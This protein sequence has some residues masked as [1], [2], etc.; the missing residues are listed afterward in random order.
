MKILITGVSGFIGFSLADK[1]LKLGYNVV[2]LDNNN[3]Y[4]SPKF[5]KKRLKEIAKYKN[6]KFLKIDISNKKQLMKI[7]KYKF[8]YIFHFAAQP[9]VRYSLVNPSLYYSSNIIG[10]QNLFE[11][12]NFKSI[13]KVFYASSSSVYGEQKKFP[14]NENSK[15]NAKNPYG[16]SKIINENLAEI[17]SFTHSV[18]FIG[19]R[20][21]TVYG[22]WGRPDMFILKLLDYLNKKKIFKL[23]NS[24]NHYRDFTYIGDVIEVC[25]KLMKKKFKIGNNL[26]NLCAGDNVNILKL[27]KEILNYFPGKANLVRNVSADKADVYKTFGNNKKIRKILRNYKFKKIDYG[28]KKTINWFFYNSQKIKY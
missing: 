3:S 8:D 19:L 18:P 27:K 25:H 1:L 7:S 22:E 17:L 23:N 5:K 15:L 20:L 6:F 14:I 12:I 24:G 2:G 9:G 16:M 11:I 4:Y 26:L 13:K 28:L 10:F 21:F